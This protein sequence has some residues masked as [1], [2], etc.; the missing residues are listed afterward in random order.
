MGVDQP[1]LNNDLCCSQTVWPVSRWTASK[2][3]GAAVTVQNHDHFVFVQ[4]GR[5]RHSIFAFWRLD[6]ALPYF[7]SR[8]V[9]TKQ[10]VGSEIDVNMPFVPRPA[11]RMRD[12]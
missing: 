7:V 5:G 3:E 12:Y 6:S 8:M 10:P 9:V 2:R 1:A 4:Y 11:C